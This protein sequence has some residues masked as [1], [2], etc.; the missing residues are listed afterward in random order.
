MELAAQVA[1]L[2][3]MLLSG[4]ETEFPAP[5]KDVEK[6]AVSAYLVLSHACI[7]EYVEDVFLSHFDRVSELSRLPIAPRALASLTFASALFLP[8]AKI[9]VMS[10]KSRTLKGALAAARGTYVGSFINRNDGL[11]ASNIKRLAEGVGIEWDRLEARFVDELVDLDTLG[12]KR[13]E[14]GHIS[15]F[16]AP[17]VTERIYPSQARQWVGAGRDAIVAI[18][19]FLAH[20]ASWQGLAE[21]T[22]PG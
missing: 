15:P 19:R 10:Y 12:A 3:E 8:E 16:S 22:M 20:D 17:A 1:A 2:E 13:G 4:I 18:Q 6:V 11:K 7:E 5:L 14:A 9:K 21:A